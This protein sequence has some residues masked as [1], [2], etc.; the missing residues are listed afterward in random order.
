MRLVLPMLSSLLEVYSGLS[1][2][3][4]RGGPRTPFA[5]QLAALANATHGP[6]AM[7]G[8]RTQSGHLDLGLQVPT[9][10]TRPAETGPQM[11]RTFGP[12]PLLLMLEMGRTRDKGPLLP[13]ATPHPT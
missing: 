9:V 12:Q 5:A 1:S 11:A 3:G 7:P 8:A 13:W 4:P 2:R 6:K 10:S